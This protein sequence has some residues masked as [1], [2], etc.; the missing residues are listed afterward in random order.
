MEGRFLVLLHCDAC[1]LT[2]LHKPNA[3]VFFI[4]LYYNIIF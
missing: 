4:L 3:I 1:F 2:L